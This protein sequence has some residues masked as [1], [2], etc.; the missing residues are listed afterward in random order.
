MNTIGI[1]NSKLIVTNDDQQFLA[2]F[3]WFLALFQFSDVKPE[4]SPV[5]LKVPLMV[6]LRMKSRIIGSYCF[7]QKICQRWHL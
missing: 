1:P 4:L 5:Q 6:G 7:P 2:Q 3:E